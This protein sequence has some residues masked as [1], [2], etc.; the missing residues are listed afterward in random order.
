MEPVAMNIVKR[1]SY[2][3]ERPEGQATL[4]GTN[5]VTAVAED[6]YDFTDREH[7]KDMLSIMLKNMMRQ[8]GCDAHAAGA[9]LKDEADEAVSKIIAQVWGQPQTQQQAQNQAKDDIWA[10]PQTQNNNSDVWSQLQQL[11]KD[12]TWPRRPDNGIIWP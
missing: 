9:L 8:N 7:R 10:Q 3:A 2:K 11:E 6:T 12:D 1:T 5:E 4:G